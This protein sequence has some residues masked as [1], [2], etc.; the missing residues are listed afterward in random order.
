MSAGHVRRGPGLIDEDQAVG[1]EVGLAV[2][3]GPAPPQDVRAVLLCGAG[4]LFFHVIRRR[5]K[6]RRSVPMPADTP[7][8]ANSTRIS[9]RVRS[10]FPSTRRRMSAACASMRAER[11]SPPSGPGATEPASRASAAQR[12]ALDGLTPK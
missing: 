4:R 9:F 6:N 3:P 8:L 2:E 7:A 12:I 11:R 5:S 10:D 1:I